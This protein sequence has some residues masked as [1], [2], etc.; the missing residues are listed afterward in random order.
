[1][2]YFLKRS[3]VHETSDDGNVRYTV[4]YISVVGW[5]ALTVH[6]YSDILN[7]VSCP[8]FFHSA[9]SS[10][11]SVSVFTRILFGIILN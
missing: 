9:C 2:R 6:Q 7:L 3:Y 10:A 11:N 8:S 1:V 5:Y 4:P